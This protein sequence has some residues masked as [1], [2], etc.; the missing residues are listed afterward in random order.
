M[1]SIREYRAALRYARHVAAASRLHPIPE[2][3][4]GQAWILFGIG[5]RETAWGTSRFLD[6][7]GPGGRGDGGHGRGLMQIDDRWHKPFIASGMWADAF[8]NIEYATGLLASNFK[9]FRKR[10]LVDDALIAASIAAYNAGAGSVGRAVRKGDDPDSV[11]TGRDYA[12]DVARRSEWYRER[13]GRDFRSPL[14]RIPI[15]DVVSL[16]V[17]AADSPK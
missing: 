17:R 8:A 11:T 2:L 6:E 3:G 13:I 1:P 16:P 14:E 12:A 15:K 7:P 5:S 10:G 4:D 9:Y